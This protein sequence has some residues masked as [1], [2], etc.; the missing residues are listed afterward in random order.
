MNP[1]AEATWSSPPEPVHELTRRLRY[2]YA[3]RITGELNI[4]E[5]PGR[6]APFPDDLDPRLATALR[7]RGIAQLYSHQSAAWSMAGSGQD[8]VGALICP[9]FSRLREW[10]QR[11]GIDGERLTEQPAVLTMR[12]EAAPGFRVRGGSPASPGSRMIGALE[13]PRESRVGWSD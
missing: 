9:D 4:P 8:F 1:Q 5:R 12:P 3:A 6:Y 10:A 7:A 13:D 2:K 11:K